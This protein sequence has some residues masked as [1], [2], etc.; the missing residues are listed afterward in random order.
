MPKIPRILLPLALAALLC[1]TAQAQTEE[2][3]KSNM[4]GR[5]ASVGLHYLNHSSS[6]IYACRMSLQYFDDQYHIGNNIFE[7]TFG[8]NYLSINPL[9]I[10][11]FRNFYFKPH[12]LTEIAVA[13]LAVIS[14]PRFGFTLGKNLDC[15]FGW[16]A[17]KLTRMNDISSAWYVTGDLRAGINYYVT[18]HLIISGY[19]EFNHTHNPFTRSLNWALGGLGVN[20]PDQ[21]KALNGHS[22]G[23]QI[24]YGLF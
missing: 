11:G 12:Y 3:T 16:D 7:I 19:Y 1:T 22:V 20:I 18:K 2:T 13:V 21:P 24:G 14:S 8:T 15:Y 10:G 17:F 5:C 9:G 23:I 6:S 4:H